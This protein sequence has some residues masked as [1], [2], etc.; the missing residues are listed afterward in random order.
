VSRCL[1]DEDALLAF[2]RNLR[3]HKELSSEH[4]V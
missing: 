4:G 2:Q 3:D 1:G